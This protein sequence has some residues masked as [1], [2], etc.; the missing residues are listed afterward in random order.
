[1]KILKPALFA[2]VL[3][4]VPAGAAGAE[5]INLRDY[6][7]LAE[8]VNPTTGETASFRV[9]CTRGATQSCSAGDHS[10]RMTHLHLSN[11]IDV[12]RSGRD[13]AKWRLRTIW[14]TVLS[15][16]EEGVVG[17]VAAAAGGF[18]LADRRFQPRRRPWPTPLIF[19]M[20]DLRSAGGLSARLATVRG[21]KLIEKSD[22]RLTMWLVTPAELAMRDA[23]TAKT[24]AAGKRKAKTVDERVAVTLKRKTRDA[25]LALAKARGWSLDETIEKL[26][27]AFRRPRPA[28]RRRNDPRGTVRRGRGPRASGGARSGSRC[29]SFPAAR[30]WPGLSA[31]WRLGREAG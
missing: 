10:P 4:T 23:E 16:D 25:V 15:R 11:R 24:G 28:P 26:I 21:G 5:P 30:V 3:A 20:D 19:R 14:M 9:D 17:V 13:D 29:R 27:E 6:W 31:S 18:A 8:I 7:I 12:Q 1:M 2:A 22:I